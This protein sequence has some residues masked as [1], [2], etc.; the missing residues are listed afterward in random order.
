[1]HEHRLP[2]LHRRHA[3]KQLVAGHVGED[4]AH[5]LRRVEVRGHLDRV[6]LRHADTLRVRAPHHQRGDTVSHLQPRAP[7]AEL[8]DDTDELVARRERRLR[9]T[10][11]DTR[12][13][14]RIAERHAGGQNPHAHLARRRSGIVLLD[15]LQDLGA[16]VVINHDALHAS[17]LPSGPRRFL[18]G[19][20]P[21]S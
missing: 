2:A 9:A 3:V 13:Q 5:D 11:I 8:L 1:M 16:T 14:Q 7:G 21:I 12:T 18:E 4:E 6:L 19:T 17:S 10:E 15:H 20:D